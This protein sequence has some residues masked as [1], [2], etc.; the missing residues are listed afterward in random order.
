MIC[1][2]GCNVLRDVG[3]SDKN[4]DEVHVLRRCLVVDRRSSVIDKLE[5]VVA[6]SLSR[7][8]QSI[9]PKAFTGEL[10]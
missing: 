1:P 9:L 5:T 8:R 10:C 4:Y 7:L 3:L 6:A 2:V